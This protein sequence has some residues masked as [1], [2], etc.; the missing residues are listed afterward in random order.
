MTDAQFGAAGLRSGSLAGLITQIRW[1]DSSSRNLVRAILIAASLLQPDCQRFCLY[2]ST[3][4]YNWTAL[5]CEDSR[6]VVIGENNIVPT[7]YKPT[8]ESD[9]EGLWRIPY[10]KAWGE[11]PMEKR[12]NP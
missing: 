7:D 1:F 3:C 12:H 6:V 10:P 8:A 4:W 9:Y 5:R 11:Y 2:G